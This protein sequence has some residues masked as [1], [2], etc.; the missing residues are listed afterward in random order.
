MVWF[1]ATR[2]D[3]G[4]PEAAQKGATQTTPDRSSDRTAGSTTR[5]STTT[6]PTTVAPRSA[7]VVT[8]DVGGAP[9]MGAPTGRTL[10]FTDQGASVLF[11]LDVDSGQLR[12]VP[13]KA[14]IRQAVVTPGRVVGI[15]DDGRLAIVGN[16]GHVE[17]E[18]P[19]VGLAGVGDGSVWVAVPDDGHL[20]LNHLVPASDL[21][22]ESRLTPGP[23]LALAGSDAQ[24]NPVV[25]GADG[26]PYSVTGDGTAE[27]L[28][29]GSMASHAFGTGNQVVAGAYADMS[30]SVQMV[31]TDVLH[32]ANGQLFQLKS[33]DPSARSYSFS[34]D[35]K[36]VA[37]N[38]AAAHRIEVFD[39]SGRPPFVVDVVDVVDA[40]AGQTPVWSPDGRYVFTYLD[41]RRALGRRRAPG[42]PARSS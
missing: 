37:V 42:A 17:V 8:V 13:V 5:A 10:H 39:F 28:S 9:L 1:L 14:G 32:A 30:C 36:R 33:T 34:P 12:Q 29:S 26:H 6:K 21:V 38:D 7:T 41:R 40:G 16:D 2:H 25:L 15:T 11:S 3:E 20:R 31:C 22:T 23:A 4:S 24:R 27:L 18:S 19:A 35:G